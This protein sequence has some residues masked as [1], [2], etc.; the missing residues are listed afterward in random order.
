ME[1]QAK[2]RSRPPTEPR[3]GNHPRVY[4]FVDG[5]T[6]AQNFASRTDRPVATYR[7]AAKQAL[8]DMGIE[9]TLRWDQHAGCSMCPCSPGFVM[10]GSGM[11]FAD[12]Y[13]TITDLD[14][15]PISEAGVDRLS[16]LVG[17]EAAR[18][19]ADV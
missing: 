15:Q 18:K 13:V 1:V 8:A 5:E 12:V 4:V 14:P 16:Q 17:S 2:I 6:M 9:G 7:K 11:Q 19:V 10:S 3:R